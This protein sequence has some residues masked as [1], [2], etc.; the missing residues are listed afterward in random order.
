MSQPEE[1]GSFVFDPTHPGYLADP[2]PTYRLLR[3]RAPVFWAA[4]ADAWLISRHADVSLG[5]RDPRFAQDT[6]N[7]HLF[8]TLPPG[9][10]RFDTLA[11]MFRAWMLFQNPPEHTRLRGLV[12]KAFTPRI[13]DHLRPEMVRL[14]DELLEKA[15]PA[16]RMDLIGELAFPLPVTVI[17][18]LLGVPP[19]D[20]ARFR[21]WSNTLAVTL[22][23]I[24]PVEALAVAEQ[25]AGEMMDYF[26]VLAGQKRAA[27]GEDLLS[28]LVHAEE[29]GRR[30][31]TEELL[32]NAV[33]LLAA[34]HETTVNLIGNGLLA[35]LRHPQQ[36]ARLRT[37]PGLI[38]NAVEELNR[39]DSPVQMT[40]RRLT[41]DVT[42]SGQKVPAGAQVLLLLGSANRDPQA[43]PDPDTLDLGRADVHPLSFGGG[44]HYCIGAPLARAEA[45]VAIGRVI[46]R[47]PDLRLATDQ[48]RHR[49]M[50]VL[51]G[52]VELPVTF[53][54]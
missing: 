51:R 41:E 16:R 12:Q 8:G 31:S 50:A 22:E 11:R 20:H 23:P 53:G 4:N 26:R 15:L 6:G 7:E 24:V 36:R 25:A 46:Q 10:P 52:V 34:G 39:Y 21:R 35:L 33:L 9:A 14:V 19:G 27:P 17:A 42:L 54:T 18:L 44:P 13:I 43:F 37:D 5:L 45:Q 48:P 47:L 3:E 40:A 1:A 29:Q 49:P 38:R 28:A 32:A 30:L 2:Y